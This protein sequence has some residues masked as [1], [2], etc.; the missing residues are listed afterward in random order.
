[1]FYTNQGEITNYKEFQ[2]TAV[3]ANRQS[4]KMK[5]VG[6]DNSGD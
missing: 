1:M 6:T 2:I 4:D 3:P 5:E